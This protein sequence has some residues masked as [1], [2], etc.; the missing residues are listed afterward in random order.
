LIGRSHR[1]HLTS[2][3][4]RW[5]KTRRCLILKIFFNNNVKV[6]EGVMYA[7]V[8]TFQGDPEQID[9]GLRLFSD[10]TLPAAL[11]LEGFC[12]ATLLGDRQSGKVMAVTFWDSEQH[13]KES[14][15]AADRLRQSAAK[16]LGSQTAPA[17][18]RFEVLRVAL[19]EAFEREK[20]RWSPPSPEVQA[21]APT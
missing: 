12:G 14:E 8:T 2:L 11:Q 6:E 3:L 1:A 19:E 13:M 10:Q 5:S 9:A 15:E 21:E 4:L 20:P 16:D 7:R 18:E 17:V